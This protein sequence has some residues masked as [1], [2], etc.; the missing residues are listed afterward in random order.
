[1]NTSNNYNITTSTFPASIVDTLIGFDNIFEYAGST[2]PQKYPP[3]NFIKRDDD[4]SY[5]EMAVAG[6]S[7]DELTITLDPKTR[8]LAIKGSSSK[9][10]ESDKVYVHRGLAARDFTREFILGEYMQIDK[11]SLVNGILTIEFVREI[12]EDEKPVDIPIGSTQLLT[13]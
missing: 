5:V 7:E 9:E 4:S 13:E 8:T 3:Y 10:A 12:P 6:F 11:T 2:K 1:M